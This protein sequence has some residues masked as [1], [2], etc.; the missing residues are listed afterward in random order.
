MQEEELGYSKDSHKA[1]QHHTITTKKHMKVFF[2][3]L[4]YII[5]NRQ[6]KSVIVMK[7]TTLDTI[8]DYEELQMLTLRN[9]ECIS[10]ENYNRDLCTHQKLHQVGYS[11]IM[12]NRTLEQGK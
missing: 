8:L 7:N 1:K 11:S 5:S 10:K 12:V 3:E 6:A 4:G 2:H 9:K